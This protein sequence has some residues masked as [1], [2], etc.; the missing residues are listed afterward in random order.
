MKDIVCKGRNG[1]FNFGSVEILGSSETAFVDVFSTQR[2]K[3]APITLRGKPEDLIGVFEKALDHLGVL[4]DSK[5][6]KLRVIWGESATCVEEKDFATQAERSAYIE[7]LEDADGWMGCEAYVPDEHG[8]YDLPDESTLAQLR[9]NGNAEE[10]L[11]SV[12]KCVQCGCSYDS[13]RWGTDTHCQECC[14]EYAESA[15]D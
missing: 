6:Y 12:K 5:P 3:T 13:A 14:D 7:A 8:S 10:F 1:C 9:C 11:K 15:I 4:L 2:G